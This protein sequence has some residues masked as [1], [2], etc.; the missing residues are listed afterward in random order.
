MNAEN[1]FYKVTVKTV[2]TDPESGKQKKRSDAYIV[3]GISP[4]DVEVKVTQELEGYEF[5]IHQMT[6][7]KIM[8]VVGS[9][10]EDDWY[11]VVI[12]T[13]YED[14]RGKL[15]FKKEEYVVQGNCPTDVETRIHDHLGVTDF[16]AVQISLTNIVGIIK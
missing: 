5:D 12:K 15:K 10:A 1:V 9:G 14:A 11:K 3:E 8:E 7:T 13:E 4:T 16:E 2:T 6:Q